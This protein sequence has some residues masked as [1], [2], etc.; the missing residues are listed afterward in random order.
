MR[1]LAALFVFLATGSAQAALNTDSLPAGAVGIIGFDFASFR[2]TRFGQAIEQ[3]AD[4]KGKDLEASRKLS[5]QLG[6]DTKSDLRDLIIGVYPG[7]DGK[8]SEQN[9]SAIVQ[10]HGRFQPATIDAFGAKNGLPSKQVGK[11]RAWE[12]GLFI[13]RLTGEKPKDNARDA[14]V[15]AHSESLVIIASGEFLD[16]ALAAADRPAK[17]SLLPAAVAAKFAAARQGWLYLYADATKMPNAKE[18]VGAEEVALVLGENATDLQLAADAGFVSA[19]KASRTRK[20][21]KGLQ[22][23]L[24]IGLAD[25]DGKSPAEK[26]NLALLG[27]LVQKIRLAG[28]GKQVTLD[29]DFPADKAVQAIAKVVEK[30]RGGA[31]APAAK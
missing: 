6:I 29:L 4:I 9:A 5:D 16:R 21:I 28:E 22:A 27:E 10:I 17:T 2:A 24:M 1:T 11:Y 25:D 20:Q 13:E 7:P 15:V 14:Y 3:L 23:F 18:E 26:E 8:V 31:A 30:S 19:E 12:A